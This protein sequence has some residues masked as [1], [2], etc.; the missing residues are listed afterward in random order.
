MEINHPRKFPPELQQCI[1]MEYRTGPAQI[2]CGTENKSMRLTTR[3]ILTLLTS[4]STFHNFNSLL[5][6]RQLSIRPKDLSTQ[7]KICVMDLYENCHGPLC[8]MQR[9]NHQLCYEDCHFF[10]LC[11]PYYFNTTFTRTVS[12]LYSSYD[13]CQ[14]IIR[15]MRIF[16]H[17]VD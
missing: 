16:A 4:S 11:I 7:T 17:S 3:Q 14:L 5:G 1:N 6:L 9:L 12:Q 13:I 8:P 15:R 10:I 2:P